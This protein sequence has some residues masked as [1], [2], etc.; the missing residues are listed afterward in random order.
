MKSTGNITKRNHYVPRW[1]QNR[2]MKEGQT[3]YWCLDKTKESD[4]EYYD[5]PRSFFQQKHLY[6]LELFGQRSD[7]IE[8]LLFGD[9]DA[10]GHKAIDIITIKD[11]WNTEHGHQRWQ[12]FIEFMNAQKLRTPKGLDWIKKGLSRIPGFQYVIQNNNFVL[13]YMQSIRQMYCTMWTEAI[14]E[15]VSAYNSE[16][17]FIVSDNPVTFYNYRIPPGADGNTYPDEPS[18]EMIGTQTIYPLSLNYCLILTHRQLALDPEEVNPIESRINARYYDQAIFSFQD[19]V[20]CRELTAEN[21]CIFNYVLKKQAKSH[22]SAAKKDWLYP[23]KYVGNLDWQEFHK[24]FIPPKDEVTISTGIFIGHRDGSIDGFDPFGQKITDPKEIEE[25]KRCNRIVKKHQREEEFS[26]ELTEMLNKYD[27]PTIEEQN[28]L[29]I[30]GMADIFEVK[31]KNLENIKNEFSA[32]KVRQLYMLIEDLWPAGTDVFKMLKHEDGFNLIYSGEMDFQALSWKLLNLG[33]Y[34]DKVY[35]TN[36]FTHPCCVRDS[37]NPL[38]NPD[39]YLIT[40]YNMILSII[41]LIPWITTG[42]IQILPNPFALDFS[43]RKIT[44]DNIEIRKKNLDFQQDEEFVK[45]Q[46]IKQFER[47]LFITPDKSLEHTIKNLI[48]NTPENLIA[49]IAKDIRARKE[50]TPFIWTK[51]LKEIGPQFLMDKICENMETIIYLAHLTNAVPYIYLRFKKAEM[52]SINA[53]PASSTEHEMKL[54]DCIDG[55]FIKALKDCGFL[56]D[57]RVVLR[58]MKNQPDCKELHEELKEKIAEAEKDWQDANNA[59]ETIGKKR[60]KTYDTKILFNS[61]QFDLPLIQNH[62]KDIYGDKSLS[63]VKMYLS[64]NF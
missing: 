50:N 37:Y 30:E 1:Y 11:G 10:M 3:Q 6:T 13:N 26:K 62:I 20:Y 48:P 49:E 35:I 23:E 43:F 45:I 17:K 61:G 19:I 47:L 34:F 55:C 64:A 21:V 8:K 56:E 25:I 39:Q 2:F 22:I 51:S 44:M 40:T 42:Q 60:Y 27:S 16:I 58:K 52:E 24:L 57:V 7:V 41:P 4:N 36:P 14:W 18:L 32:D 12:D 53:I 63:D 9:I 29:L 46:Y 38:K 33:L 54:L 28:M 15:I 59:I 5:I 31:G